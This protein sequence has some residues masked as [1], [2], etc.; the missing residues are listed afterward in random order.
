MTSKILVIY[1]SQTGNTESFVDYLEDSYDHDFKV[2]NLFNR[3]P[4]EEELRWAD[5]I[6]LGTYTWAD[7]KIP[8]QFK[9]FVIDF[10]SLLGEKTLFLFGSG[11]TIY[12]HF[13]RALDNI[14]IILGRTFPKIKFE[15]TFIEEDNSD[16][17]KIIK[18]E[19]DSIC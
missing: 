15:L 14:E 4:K 7:G 19:F 12:P 17:I 16:N 10:S 2:V 6:L 3:R 18:K 11:I 5:H 1:N 13:C 9:Q 8:A